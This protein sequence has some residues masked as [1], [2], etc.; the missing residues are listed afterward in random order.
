MEEGDRINNKILVIHAA[1]FGL[2]L[3]AALFFYATN[4]A[5]SIWQHWVLADKLFNFALVSYLVFNCISQM[6]ILWIFWDL[7]DTLDQEALEPVDDTASESAPSIYSFDEEAQ[8][9]ARIW[10]RFQAD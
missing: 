7:G 8:L 5:H 1:A 4:T 3:V 10:N 6:L 2:Y 9:Q